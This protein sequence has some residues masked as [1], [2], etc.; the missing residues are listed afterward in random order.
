MT[1]DCDG[2]GRPVLFKDVAAILQLYG[3]CKAWGSLPGPGGIFDQNER[4]MALL[5]TVEQVFSEV[6]KKSQDDAAGEAQKERM[7]RDL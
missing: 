7:L 4:T 5:D 3:R 1:R 6:R 2:C